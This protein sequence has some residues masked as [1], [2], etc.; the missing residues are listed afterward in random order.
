M[1]CL[2][3]MARVSEY[4][5]GELSMSE[6]QEM[7]AHFDECTNCRNT[8]NELNRLLEATKLSIESIPV[9]PDL[10]DKILLNIQVEKHKATK[11]LWFTSI[12]LILLASPLL[13]FLTHTF[14]SI[15][16]LFYATSAVLYR[17]LI[18]LISFV[19]PWLMLSFGI[20]LGLG[21]TISSFI[22][23]RLIHDLQL[24]GVFQ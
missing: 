11:N 14:Y 17:F 16:H 2:K 22:I 6:S 13:L 7:K 21:I 19:P 5:D 1:E 9:P 15:A 18:T 10:T 23:K 20:L 3:C 4:L 8:I 12:L 24:N